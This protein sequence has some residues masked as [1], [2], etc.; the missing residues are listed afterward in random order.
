[1]KIYE[2]PT[3]PRDQILLGHQGKSQLDTGFIFADYEER[4]PTVIERLAGVVDD[5]IQER[6]DK[7]DEARGKS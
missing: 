3:Y 7:M 1:M 5:E 2:D 4:V 6:V